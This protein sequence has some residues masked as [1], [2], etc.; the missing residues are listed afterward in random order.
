MIINLFRNGLPDTGDPLQLAEPGASDGSCRAEMA[1]QCP[2]ALCPNTC[3][4]IERRLAK[5]FG[6]LSAVRSDCEAV[7]LVPQALQKVEHGVPWVER[8]WRS[9]GQKKPL[10]PGVAVW[11]FSYC[12]NGNIINA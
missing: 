1:K 8:E 3:D 11:T 2:L 7:R 12:S 6:P 4:L 5:C 9:P 10:A